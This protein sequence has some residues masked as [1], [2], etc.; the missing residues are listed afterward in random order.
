MLYKVSSIIPK[1]IPSALSPDSIFRH[2]HFGMT[3]ASAMSKNHQFQL[4]LPCLIRYPDSISIFPNPVMAS[5]RIPPENLDAL[6]FHFILNWDVIYTFRAGHHAVIQ[7]CNFPTYCSLRTVSRDQLVS[8][9][10]KTF[11]C[12]VHVFDH[13]TKLRQ[14][15]AYLCTFASTYLS[16]FGLRP[17]LQRCIGS[18]CGLYIF[19]PGLVPMEH[20][21]DF[22]TI[23]HLQKLLT[24][25]LFSSPA[26]LKLNLPGKLVIRTSG[27]VLP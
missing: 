18:S 17:L 19:A 23:L 14:M 8:R 7:R 9:S 24:L 4:E 12:A 6:H 3:A 27:A 11:S 21:T 10:A 25:A 1:T 22:R 2:F 5:N 26:S 15:K 13:K 20:T 16:E